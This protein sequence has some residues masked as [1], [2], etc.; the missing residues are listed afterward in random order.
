MRKIRTPI[1]ETVR[2]L[3]ERPRFPLIAALI[4]VLLTLPSLWNGLNLDD[5]FSRIAFNDRAI[6]LFSTIYEAPLRLF[7]LIDDANRKPWMDYGLLPWWTSERIQISFFR[8]IASMFQTLDHR[9]WQSHPFMMHLHSLFWFALLVFSISVYYRNIFRTPWVAGLAALLFAVDDAHGFTVGWLANRHSILGAFFVVIALLQFDRWN[10][11]RNRTDLWIALLYYLCGLLSSE[12]A[13]ATLGY[14]IAYLVFIDRGSA[15][16]RIAGFA[17]FLVLTIVWRI[18]YRSLGYG[19]FDTNHYIDPLRE[20]PTFVTRA[21]ERGPI[22]LLSQLGFPPAEFHFYLPP[23]LANLLYLFALAYLALFA[24]VLFPLL[25]RDSVSRFWLAGMLL[26]LPPACAPFPDDRNIIVLGIGGMGLTAR[27]LQ[28][29]LFE[30]DATDNGGWR[31][32]L[33]GGFALVFIG[34]HLV[35]APGLLVIKSV[36]PKIFHNLAEAAT[37]PPDPSISKHHYVILNAPAY[38]PNIT[39]LIASRAAR[40]LP[41]P[42]SAWGLATGDSALNVTRSDEKTLL[43]KAKKGFMS[44]KMDWS[45]R[46]KNH[47]LKEGQIVR[48]DGMSAEIRSLLAD[49]RPSEVR[50]RFPASLDDPSFVWLRWEKGKFVRFTPP[51]TGGSRTFD[52]IRFS[53]ILE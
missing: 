39:F 17:P 50:F 29:A 35:I 7:T 11:R 46:S 30:R 42:L 13:I 8:P 44:N 1:T 32:K 31:T 43:I 21:F 34:I 37:I 19:V 18:V 9:L 22:N 33:S 10:R 28:Y 4:A 5:N 25:K 51:A 3:L 14:L 2:Q 52:E 45:M 47:P 23:F 27:F 49:G 16:I 48:V 20:F 24:F 53:E 12:V 36:T 6:P 41:L 15:K 26:S 40:N 38:T